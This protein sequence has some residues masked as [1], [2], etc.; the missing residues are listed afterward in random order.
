MYGRGSD[1]WIRKTVWKRCRRR[2]GS[3]VTG[4]SVATA[5][6]DHLQPGDRASP[7]SSRPP[8][9]REEPGSGSG[10]SG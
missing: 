4:A 10:T 2:T 7:V 1:G 8:H 6:P 3:S 5:D 9:G